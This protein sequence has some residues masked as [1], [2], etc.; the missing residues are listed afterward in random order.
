MEFFNDLEFVCCGRAVKANTAYA[1][2]CFDGYY[3]LQFI[4]HGKILL[5]VGNS[6]TL[7]AQGPV[8]FFTSP[9]AP[10]SYS[11]PPGGT[12]E[13]YFVC[14]KGPRAEAYK[15]GG[16]LPEK[17]QAVF[18]PVSRP[19]KFVLTWKQLLRNRRQSGVYYHAEAVMALEKLLVD[20][21][22][23]ASSGKNST[24]K[25][26][27]LTDLASRIADDPGRNWNFDQEAAQLG[28]S[29]V[30]F[31]RLFRQ[32]TGMPLW[33]YVL[34]CRIR[35]ASQLLISTDKLIKEIAHEC[36]FNGVFHF[37]REFKKLMNQSPDN[38]RKS[39]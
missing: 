29:I 21:S 6:E 17:P 1:A 28:L 18:Y 14:F 19:E 22:F 34:E 30:H 13:H 4:Y 16:L 23:S 5:K 36:G 26:D 33:H 24:F 3:G 9:G 35:Y 38:F 15:K 7:Q 39:I 25:Q 32:T 20:V 8:C 11:C 10:F 2:H 12:R 27:Q 37:S 31:R